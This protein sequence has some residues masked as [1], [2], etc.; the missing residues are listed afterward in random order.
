MPSNLIGKQ[1]TLR[2]DGYLMH[3]ICGGLLAATMPAP[4]P[5]DRRAKLSGA[6]ISTEPLPP[7]P[8]QPPWAER[9]V[10][11][12]GQI[13]IA[14]QKIRLSPSHAGKTVTVIIRGHAFA[15]TAR[16]DRA[17]TRTPHKSRP[18]CEIQ[19]SRSPQDLITVKHH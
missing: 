3:V 17:Q 16:R 14:S 11:A 6:R 7:A 19:G 8:A 5:P 1:V 9:R 2:L 10:P 12:D 13:M 4:I 15:R 18:G